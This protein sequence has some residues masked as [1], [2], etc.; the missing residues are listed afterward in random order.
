MSKNHYEVLAL[1]TSSPVSRYLSQQDL[2]LAYRQ[3]LLQHHPD[4]STANSSQLLKSKYSVD[5]ITTAYKILSDS[6]SRSRYDHTLRLQS[7]EGRRD[8]EKGYIGLETVDLDDLQNDDTNGVWYRNC[9]CGNERGYLITEH[10]LEKE[11]DHGEII[12]G[13]GGCSLSLKVVF[14]LVQDG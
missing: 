13:C 1:S 5:D 4:K 3:A 12:A 10:E 2:K 11:A 7:L 9:R 6:R 14:Q 8:T